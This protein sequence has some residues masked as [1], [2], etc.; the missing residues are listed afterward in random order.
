MSSGGLPPSPVDG[1]NGREIDVSQDIPIRGR[2]RAENTPRL[3]TQCGETLEAKYVR[4][5]KGTFHVECFM[6]RVR[7]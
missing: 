6:C 5:L 7:P 4:A 1:R 2:S 3:C